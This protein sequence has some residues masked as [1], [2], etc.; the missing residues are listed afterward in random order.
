MDNKRAVVYFGRVINMCESQISNKSIEP[1][2]RV[3]SITGIIH[4]SR[5][6][7][8]PFPNQNPKLCR[9]NKN[10]KKKRNEHE[11]EPNILSVLEY[12]IRSRMAFAL[13]FAIAINSFMQIGN[14]KEQH[15]CM[16]V[17]LLSI[18]DLE[19]SNFPNMELKRKK[20]LHYKRSIA[21]WKQ[22][23]RYF[24][25]WKWLVIWFSH[26]NAQNHICT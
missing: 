7:I 12:I 3:C 19:K 8:Y 16:R 9:E 13:Q 6:F 17:C 11:T 20:N 26:T 22:K 18:A 14:E 25:S 24:C 5:S 2:L 21:F 23:L 15:T 10:G 1:F 4:V